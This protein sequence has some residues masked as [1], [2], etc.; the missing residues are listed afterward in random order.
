MAIRVHSITVIGIEARH[1]EVEV[2]FASGMPNFI[3]VGLP[4]SAV[5]ESKDRV[6]SAVKNSEHISPRSREINTLKP[7]TQEYAPMRIGKTRPVERQPKWESRWNFF[8]EIM[9]P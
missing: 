3:M 7:D 2:D 4:D 5:R 8:V 9:G 6:Q 1:V